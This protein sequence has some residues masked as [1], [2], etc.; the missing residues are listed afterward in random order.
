MT[1]KNAFNSI[2]ASGNWRE[3]QQQAERRRLG[4]PALLTSNGTSLPDLNIDALYLKVGLGLCNNV[5]Y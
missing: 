1:M 5:H 2:Q 4:A 3:I